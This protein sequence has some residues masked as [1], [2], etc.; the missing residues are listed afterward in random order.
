MALSEAEI[1]KRAWD[2]RAR[3]IARIAAVALAIVTIVVLINVITVRNVNR[4]GAT[5]RFDWTATRKHSLSPQT[6]GVLK[7]LDQPISITT[8]FA[9][10]GDLNERDAQNI[11]AFRELLDEYAHRSAGRVGT[12]H[13]R[14]GDVIA[15]DTFAAQ[16][17]ERYTEP[18]ERARR[19][20]ELGRDALT[21][22]NAM[23]QTQAGRFNTAATTFAATDPGLGE[24]FTQFAQNLLALQNQLQLDQLDHDLTLM[25][26]GAMPEMARAQSSVADPLADIH[27]GLF[28]AVTDH[29][30]AEAEADDISAELRAFYSETLAAFRDTQAKVES[31]IEALD[32]ADTEAYDRLRRALLTGNSA[33]VATETHL[34]VLALGDVYTGSGQPGTEQRFRGEEAVTGAIISLTTDTQPRVVF[35]NATQQPAIGRGGSH[36]HVAERLSNMNFEVTEWNPV[37]RVAQFGQM[38]PQPR[39]VAKEGQTLVWV[40]LPPPPLNPMSPSQT[41]LLKVSG[42]L[43]QSLENHEPTLVILPLSIMPRFGQPDPLV[44][45][46]GPLGVK[47]D[48]GKLIFAQVM[49]GTGTAH[50]ATAIQTQRWADDHPIGQALAGQSA[51]LT[52]AL[53]LDLPA[54]P[55]QTNTPLLL[56]PGETWA[57]I[58]W[59]QGSAPPTQDSN[60]PTGPFSVAAAIENDRQRAVLIGD[61]LF[62]SDSAILSQA[63]VLTPDGPRTQSVVRAAG[64]AELFV[65]SVYWLAGRDELIAT[66]ARTQDVRRFK[67]IE[68]STA[69]TVSLLLLIGLPALTLTIGVGVWMLRRQ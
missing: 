40:Y 62:A 44:Q 69:T 42:A 36:N 38:P 26:Q 39:P 20:I 59:T 50:P 19:A 10:E 51:Q 31:A 1:L 33:V 64:N 41:G 49:D 8:L 23:A 30:K 4:M 14:A 45:S 12:D 5:L 58:N 54:V 25:L 22:V 3:H 28:T 11:R 63:M 61:E 52:T 34:T 43:K 60:E 46:L 29:F 65:N 18:I 48:T 32:A 24:Q 66:G 21:D 16:L 2:R 9:S 35:V 13:V 68:P 37:G 53:A 57:E 7:D 56:T 47:A 67:P 6:L 27:D 17:I 55:N 15:V